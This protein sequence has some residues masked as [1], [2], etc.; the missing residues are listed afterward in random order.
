MSDDGQAEENQ[1]S[2]CQSKEKPH[3]IMAKINISKKKDDG[4][5]KLA[6][7]SGRIKKRKSQSKALKETICRMKMEQYQKEFKWKKEKE[8]LL[9]KLNNDREK[10]R[11]K[12][13]SKKT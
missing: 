4:L 2:G 10:V 12:S 6:N 3:S 8:I 1:V 9:Q 5:L 7:K 13:I 11:P